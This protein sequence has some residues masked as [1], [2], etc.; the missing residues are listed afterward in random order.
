MFVA[1]LCNMLFVVCG[2]CC[3]K[4]C[5]VLLSVVANNSLRVV[6]LLSCLVVCGS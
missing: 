4:L 1:V 3:L 6:D 2:V 5:V